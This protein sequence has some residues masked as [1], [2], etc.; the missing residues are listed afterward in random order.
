MV[1]TSVIAVTFVAG[2]FLTDC[3]FVVVRVR[4]L[5]LLQITNTTA[6]AGAI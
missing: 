6:R 3:M 5:S 1:G 2:S 4:I